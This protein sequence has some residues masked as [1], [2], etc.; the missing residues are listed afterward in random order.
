MIKSYLPN[1]KCYD[2][3]VKKQDSHCCENAKRSQN[4]HTL[5]KGQ[6]INSSYD[7]ILVGRGGRGNKAL[8]VEAPI[9]NAAMSEN[10]VIVMEIPACFMANP[11]LS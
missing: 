9:K 8:T 6:K 2:E 7:E 4:W 10:V 1:K 3:N 5:K 11:T